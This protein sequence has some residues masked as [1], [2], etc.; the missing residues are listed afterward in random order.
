MKQDTLSQH[1]R[2]VADVR[3]RSSANSHPGSDGVPPSVA[4]VA[5]VADVAAPTVRPH[6]PVVSFVAM[7]LVP[8]A[9]LWLVGVI[10]WV[11]RNE[12]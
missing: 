2:T 3:R 10:I 4:Q 1:S 11:V 12:A 7:V 8:I 6:P 5:D 9:L